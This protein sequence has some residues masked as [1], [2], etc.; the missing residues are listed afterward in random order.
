MRI[1]II[2]RTSILYNTALLLKKMNHEVV[3]IL[4]AKEAPEYTRTSQDFR[5]L[6]S[7]WCIPF[8]QGGNILKHIDFLHDANADIAVSIN[9][10]GII[11]QEII[12]LFPHGIL[13]AHGGD[14]PRYRGNACQAW[15]IINGETRIGLCVH[16]MIADEL[17]SGDIISREYLNINNETKITD[18]YSWMEEKTPNLMLSAVGIL[19]KDPNYVLEEQS[20]N[21]E[22]SLRC[23]PRKPEDGSIDWSKPAIEILR[24]INASGKPYSGAFCKF[25][26]QKLIVWDGALREKSENVCAMPGQVIK[27]EDD[28]VDIACGDENL[29][30][31]YSVEYEGSLA[32]PS[33][34][35]TSIRDRVY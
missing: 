17:D 12:N 24:L 34:I 28:Y 19:S 23:Y 35:F 27:I 5:E 2:G 6:A 32:C 13:N 18:V 22:S 8:S 1:A 3:C 20:K 11:P 7:M 4:T 25:Q 16:K 31:L 26:E 14:L 10:T 9:Y 15:A 21:P 33:Y 30:R 29:V